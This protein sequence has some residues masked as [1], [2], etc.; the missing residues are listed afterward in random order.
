MK[1]RLASDFL[2]QLR[3]EMLDA[4]LGARLPPLIG[5]SIVVVGVGPVWS[6]TPWHVGVREGSV[7]FLQ[8]FSERPIVPIGRQ[9]VQ[10]AFCPPYIPTTENRTYLQ[11]WAV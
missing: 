6:S 9:S 11:N 2:G 3:E 10:A 5:R 4:G 7:V 1:V 8:N